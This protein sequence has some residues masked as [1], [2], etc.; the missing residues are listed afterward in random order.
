MRT[1][2]PYPSISRLDL[3]G[4]LFPGGLITA[5]SSSSSRDEDSRSSFPMPSGMWDF[6]PDSFKPLPPSFVI[7]SVC[8]V[9]G[10]VVSGAEAL[11][12]PTCTHLFCKDCLHSY[13]MVKIRERQFPI[14]CPGCLADQLMDNYLED[15]IL[16]NLGI[17]QKETEILVEL[18][19]ALHSRTVICP[20]CKQT[21]TVDRQDY[22]D[23]PIMACPFTECCHRW[24]R[25]CG[26]E[27]DGR[28]ALH[29]CKNKKLDRLMRR[30]GWRYCPGCR[31]PIQKEAGCNHMTC[32]APGC[33]VHFCYKCGDKI[34]DL[35]L[36]RSDG[37][38]AA[39]TAHYSRC[40]QY[41]LLSTHT[42]GR[43][44]CSIQ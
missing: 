37:L 7:D 32:G 35:S 2:T 28:S 3:P 31:T 27:M 12:T 19:L 4:D 14:N 5:T 21:M 9:C 8:G 30:K 33:R 18:Q 6:G 16:Y 44:R 38:S 36:N 34:F 1:A 22:F 29:H 23:N 26:K 13:V 20:K 11:S 15:D 10:D 40:R 43:L 25:D 41:P 24:C 17:P 39:I 42:L